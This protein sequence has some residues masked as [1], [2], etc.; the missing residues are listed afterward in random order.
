[1]TVFGKFAGTPSIFLPAPALLLFVFLFRMNSFASCSEHQRRLRLTRAV[2]YSVTLPPVS[3]RQSSIL[4]RQ[5]FAEDRRAACRLLFVIKTRHLLFRILIA[6]RSFYGK[7][8]ICCV[9][10]HLAKLASCFSFHSL[11][12]PKRAGNLLSAGVS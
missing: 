10:F 6:S 5:L 11:L 12:L 2:M 1:M 3:F 7:C 9:G 8:F 4:D